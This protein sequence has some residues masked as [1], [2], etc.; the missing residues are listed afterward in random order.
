MHTTPHP[1]APRGLREK[2]PSG[3]G[4]AR[5]ETRLRDAGVVFDRSIV[6]LQPH[7][8]V[9]LFSDSDSTVARHVSDEGSSATTTEDTVPVVSPRPQGEERQDWEQEQPLGATTWRL[10]ALLNSYGFTRASLDA[11][12]T[13]EET[14]HR[15]G[16]GVDPPLPKAAPHQRRIRLLLIKDVRGEASGLR[17]PRDRFLR[18]WFASYEDV[19]KR[20]L[21]RP[22]V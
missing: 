11:R 22:S 8:R 21:A 7:D 20:V 12:E 6:G 9:H 17:R 14:L 16:L 3:D 4:L 13:V 18:S 19:W 1:R 2:R 5:L 15:E 10:E